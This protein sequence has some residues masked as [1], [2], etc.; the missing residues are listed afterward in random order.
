MS[1]ECSAMVNR[2]SCCDA[3]VLLQV[4]EYVLAREG[5]LRGVDPEHPSDRVKECLGLSRPSGVSAIFGHPTKPKMTSGGY[6][7]KSI[8]DGEKEDDDEDDTLNDWS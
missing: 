3:C 8:R 2:L 6:V 7:G 5:F 4:M 1:S